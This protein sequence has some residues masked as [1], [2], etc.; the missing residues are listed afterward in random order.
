MRL[1]RNVCEKEILEADLDDLFTLTK[2][3][4][5]FAL[6]RFIYKVKKNKTDEDYPGRTL[7]QMTC[8]I[9][10]F[11]HKKDID[12]K[13]VH[14]SEFKS[15]NHV[16]DKVMQ[17]RAEMRIG[18]VRRQAEIISLEF[19]QTLWDNNVL[20]DDNPNKLRSTVLYLL[21]VN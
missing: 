17:E 10:S 14:G 9:Q 5:E 12:W 15:F 2:E 1:D 21:G 16:L 8:A 20:V 11:L 18:T 3:N 4:L 6:C 19:E 7:Y 13:I